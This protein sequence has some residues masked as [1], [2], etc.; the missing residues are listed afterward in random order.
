MTRRRAGLV[1]PRPDERR[2]VARFYLA[3]GLSQGLYLVYPFEFAYLYLTMRRPEWSVLP[4]IVASGTTMLTQLPTGV[5][6][7]RWGRKRSVLAGGVLT[8]V[9]FVAVPS[10]VRLPGAW[11]LYGTCAAFALFG[12]GD[13]MMMGAEEAW[14]VDNLHDAGRADLVEPFFARLFAIT[15][16]GSALASGLALAMLL[17]MHV[18]QRLLDVLWYATAAGFL[19]AIAVALTIPEHR[20]SGPGGA[21]GAGDPDGA[22]GDAT[23]WARTKQALRVLVR[24]RSL[25]FLTVA[26]VVATLSGA[27]ANEA[28]P[29]S[30]LTKGMDARMLGPLGIV[31]G[32]VGFGAPLVGLVLARRLGAERLLTAVLVLAG[33]LVTMLFGVQGIWVVL[34]LYVLLGMLDQMWD[35][36]ALA[37]LQKDIPSRHRAALGSLMYE[38]EGLAQLAGLGLFGLLLGSHSQQLRDATP[39]LVEAFSGRTHPAGPAPIGLFGLSVPD[40]A[41]VSFVL[42]GVLA[43]PFVLLSGRGAR[44]KPPGPPAGGDAERSA[45]GPVPA[46][47]TRPVLG[48]AVPSRAQRAGVAAR[49]TRRAASAAKGRIALSTRRT[50]AHTRLETCRRRKEEG[51]SCGTT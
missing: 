28:F 34:V 37:R 14:V 10:T 51:P 4:L 39:D 7:D 44:G 42:V 35:P 36:V 17:T 40:L 12:L 33:A 50:P 20:P 1:W 25:L 19:A 45:A 13:T 11:Q 8:A 48:T 18:D 47:P 26:V 2:L 5:L 15:G 46:G 3:V 27:G 16:F 24:T 29:V 23:L 30:L 32:V 21:D 22:D 49:A 43:V 41:I 9:T 6:A 31:D 38:A